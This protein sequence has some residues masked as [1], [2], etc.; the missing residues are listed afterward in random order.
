M[1]LTRHFLDF[2]QPALLSAAEY[3]VERY[4]RGSAADMANAIVVLPGRRAARRLLEILVELTEQRGLLLSPPTLETVG[5]L[6]EHLYQ[7]QRPFASALTQQLAWARVLRE[8]DR[9]HL[10][11]VVAAPHAADDVA[12]WLDLAQS[13]SQLHTELAADVLDFRDVA[14]CGRELESF[15]EGQRWAALRHLQEEYLKTLDALQLWDVQTARLVAIEQREC[16]T[17]RDIV[18]VAAVDMPRTLRQM[19]QQ[20][21]AQVTVLVHAPR[22]WADRFDAEG[23]LVPEAWAAIPVPLDADRV[24]LV[25]GPAEVADMAAR[26]LAE[27]DGRY[28][29]DEITIGLADEDLAP[30][31]TR[32][33]R[34]CGIAARAAVGRATAE[35][36]PYRLLAAFEAYLRSERYGEFAALVRHPDVSAWMARGEVAANWLERL[37]EYFGRH[38][39][40]R[41][42][43]NWLG[44]EAEA[45]PVQQVFERVELLLASFQGPPRRWPDWSPAMRDTLGEVYG[46]RSWN[47]QDDSDRV[48]LEVFEQLRNAWEAVDAV[49]SPLVPVLDAATALELTLRQVR[50]AQVSPA[51]DP[52]AVELLG[53]LELPLDDAP[54]LVVCSFC[55]GLVPSSVNSDA[56]LPNTLRSR[57]GLQD[58]ARRYA[59]DAYALSVL[60][61]SRQRL[62]LIVARHN[63]QGDPLA[64]SRLLFATEREQLAPR[65]LR[66]FATPSPQRDLPP[67]AGS[68]ASGG[69]ESAFVVPRPV[70]PAEKIRELPVTAF[71]DYLACPYRF[72][73]RR[74][75]K[76]RS[77]D[78]AAEELDGGLFGSLA[79]EV[80]RQFGL[81]PCRDSTD[82][83]EIR[84]HLRELLQRC[85]EAQ[86]GQHPLASVMVQLEQLRLRLDGF[87]D[88]QAERAAAGW[89]I[90]SI[91]GEQR[92]HTDAVLQVGDDRLILRGRID[93]IDVHRETGLRAILDY[94]SSDSPRTP[95][96]AHQ[97]GDQ[98]IDLQLPLYRHLARSQGI[99]GPV[100]LGYVLLPKDVDKVEFC[101]AQ[102]SE[103]QLARADAVAC[104]VI[105]GIWDNK[106]WPPTEPAPDFSEEFA[107]ICQDGVFE[108]QLAP[109]PEESAT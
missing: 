19:L 20:V 13:V 58:N 41:L 46:A 18:V 95:E 105:R 2:S 54:A 14:R 101:M 29:A 72:Y 25:D 4:Q 60:A 50:T 7:A 39:Q 51:F 64:P 40:S 75:L 79:H 66:F 91:E 96:K 71:R 59:R 55:E 1:S 81:G 83:A 44:D 11:R 74:V 12:G 63:S 80:L 99:T 22:A 77:S 52:E 38:L 56:F 48:F 10:L 100:Q 42:S 45:R 62:D 87:A 47:R 109:E 43:G 92:E 27:W 30:Y 32:Q 82:P 103:E 94:K 85:A 88:K 106:F 31:V 17:E 57:L 98:W 97:R 37:D 84:Q 108:R 23:C 76:L 28:R 15:G 102:W 5:Q 70:P 73:L 107:A 49:P 68:L 34:D 16:R 78:D 8:A 53:W 35:T 90:E 26:C 3:L 86:Y 9:G 24:R 61:A 36:G 6:P 21:A 69:G 89:S 104:E 33:L 65:A 67:L 93:R